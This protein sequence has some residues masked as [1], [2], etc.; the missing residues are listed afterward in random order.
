VDFDGFAVEG[1]LLPLVDGFE[2]PVAFFFCSVTDG[3]SD[4]VALDVSLDN[5]FLGGFSDL[6]TFASINGAATTSATKSCPDG[7]A[8]GFLLLSFRFSTS[9]E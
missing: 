3:L 4:L 7:E 6:A 1:V 5:S 2:T 8:I 9:S